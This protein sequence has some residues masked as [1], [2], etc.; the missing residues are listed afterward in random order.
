MENEAINETIDFINGLEEQTSLNDSQIMDYAQLAGRLCSLGYEN[1]LERFIQR[2][3]SSIINKLLHKRIYDGIND[4]KGVH[5]IILAYEIITVQ[6]FACF[7]NHSPKG[8][9]DQDTKEFMDLWIRIAE[10]KSLDEKA[11][12]TLYTFHE[13]YPINKNDLLNIV[14]APM[15]DQD[16]L[17]LENVLLDTMNDNVVQNSEEQNNRIHIEKVDN[18]SESNRVTIRISGI[19]PKSIEMVRHLY[20]P[21]IRSKTDPSVW[22]FKFDVFDTSP[23]IDGNI[24][25]QKFDGSRINVPYAS[26]VASFASIEKPVLPSIKTKSTPL[27]LSA[28]DSEKSDKILMSITGLDDIYLKIWFDI[29]D[30]KILVQA[31]SSQNNRMTD[32]LDGWSLFGKNGIFL[33][34]FNGKTVRYPYSDENIPV[35]LKDKNGTSYLLTI[36]EEN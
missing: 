20:V 3:K 36:K 17:F 30:K 10:S 9:I 27:V 25:V 6:D 32:K 12:R 34:T 1:S 29:P 2:F 35:L 22:T 5:S 23:D 28:A 19:D 7:V 16:K 21:A 8:V 24:V 31:R 26:I 11:V 4:I 15:T 14:A 18:A 13:R 33:G